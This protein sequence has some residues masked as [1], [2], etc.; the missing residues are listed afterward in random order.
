MQDLRH[1]NM[2]LRHNP[3]FKQSIWFGFRLQTL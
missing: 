3:E 2:D 1:F